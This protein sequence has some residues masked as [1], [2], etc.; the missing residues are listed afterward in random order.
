MLWFYTATKTFC[1]VFFSSFY[2][3]TFTK[4]KRSLIMSKVKS[5]ET[6]P[7]VLVRKYLF[8]QGFRFRVNVKSL[9]GSP[10]IVLAKY[11]TVVLIHGCFW[12]RHSNCKHATLPKSNIE[13]WQQKISKNRVR[14][15]STLKKFITLGWQVCTLWECELNSKAKMD[16]TLPQLSE[17]IKSNKVIFRL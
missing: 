6:K 4:A 9:P 10:D 13:Y 1:L 8:S 16:A 14:D 11:K 17:K 12:H 7:E 5:T 15:E 2:M 3:D